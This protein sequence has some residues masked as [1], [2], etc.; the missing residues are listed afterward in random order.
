[1]DDSTYNS[2]QLEMIAFPS[3]AKNVNDQPVTYGPTLYD[4]LAELSTKIGGAQYLIGQLSFFLQF[5]LS[6]YDIG[7]QD[8]LLQCS[9]TT[10]NP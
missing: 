6:T 2:S 10:M 5:D 7:A 1:M 8:F 4:V 3:A 9:P